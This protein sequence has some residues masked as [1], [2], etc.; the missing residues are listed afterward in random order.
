MVT[1]GDRVGGKV[2]VAVNQEANTV[3]RQRVRDGQGVMDMAEPD[4]VVASHDEQHVATSKMPLTKGPVLLVVDIDGLG[5]FYSQ[6]RDPASD[7]IRRRDDEGAR[8]KH[9]AGLPICLRQLLPV[10]PSRIV[11][12]RHA[13]AHNPTKMGVVCRAQH[14]VEIRVGQQASDRLVHGLR[15]D[16]RGRGLQRDNDVKRLV[17]RGACGA[18]CFCDD[19]VEGDLIT[20]KF[21]GTTVGDGAQRLRHGQDLCVVAGHHDDRAEG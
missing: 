9:A 11:G 19:A 4:L 21:V 6:D 10:E 20:P 14:R 13:V 2:T 15:S 8:R 18:K 17:Q 7:A 12:Y 16:Q 5:P 1:F 3:P